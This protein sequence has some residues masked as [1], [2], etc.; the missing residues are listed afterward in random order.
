MGADQ[1]ESVALK[2]SGDQSIFHRC[3]FMS[4]QVSIHSD[5]VGQQLYHDCYISGSQHLIYGDGH[6][7]FQR[8]T[9]HVNNLKPKVGVV[10]A[11]QERR[12]KFLVGEGFVFHLFTFST[13]TQ[14]GT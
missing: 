2:N 13:S 10:I 5:H 3:S 9:I 8:S 14:K 7:M 6:A 1:L 4:Q 11:L 12:S